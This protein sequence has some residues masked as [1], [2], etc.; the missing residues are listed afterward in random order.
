MLKNKYKSLKIITAVAHVGG[1]DLFARPWGGPWMMG[2]V[3]AG[4][5][6]SRVLTGSLCP[7]FELSACLV[8]SGRS[9]NTALSSVIV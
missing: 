5:D 3:D 9:Q 4:V 2:R 7:P 8:L 1:R 6:W